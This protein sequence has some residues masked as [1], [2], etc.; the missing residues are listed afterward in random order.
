M[1]K[2]FELSLD[3]LASVSGGGGNNSNS[4]TV[5]GT[6]CNIDTHVDRLGNT[7]VTM[8]CDSVQHVDPG[9]KN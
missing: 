3:D 6:N 2:N 8:T 9:K 4:I 5:K 1:E 7:T